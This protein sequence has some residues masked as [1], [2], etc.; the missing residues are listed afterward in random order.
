MSGERLA[1]DTNVLAYAFDDL[2]PDRQARAREVIGRA[3]R[4]ARCILSVQSVGELHAVLRRR[5]LVPA[6]AL[7]Q[8]VRDLVTLF[9]IEGI[10]PAD[11]ELALSAAAAG[12]LSYWDALLIATVTRAGCSVVLSEDMQ[13]GAKVAG[14]T[15]RNP[16]LGPTLPETIAVLLD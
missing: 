8:S 14:A 10:A 9:P 5:R 4:T 11:A 16:F 13:D 3:A 12:Q 6:A 2:E 15:L 1:L 7:A